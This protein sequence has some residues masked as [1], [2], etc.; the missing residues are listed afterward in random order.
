[1][2]ISINLGAFPLWIQST[3]IMVF[4]C[5][6]LL[7]SLL[8]IMHVCKR[9]LRTHSIHKRPMQRL[10]RHR[11]ALRSSSAKIANLGKLIS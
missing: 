6:S 11:K 10:P 4:L 3:I 8:D 2:D 5:V 7:R 9:L 1:M